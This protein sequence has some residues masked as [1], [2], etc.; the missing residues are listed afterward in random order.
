MVYA[1][2]ENRKLFGI[3]VKDTATSGYTF[4]LYKCSVRDFDCE[5]SQVKYSL[6]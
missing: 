5:V 1:P 6:A 2:A 4:Y 3:T